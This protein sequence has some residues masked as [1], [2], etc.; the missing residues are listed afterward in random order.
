MRTSQVVNIR[1]G[2]IAPSHWTHRV[3]PFPKKRVF[4][5][6][7]QL[8]QDQGLL[9]IKHE[10]PLIMTLA[11][12]KG[13]AKLEGWS[14]P[15]RRDKIRRRIIWLSTNTTRLVIS[16]ITSYGLRGGVVIYQITPI[17]QRPACTPREQE[18]I[19][20]EYVRN[21]TLPTSVTQ[22][23]LMSISLTWVDLVH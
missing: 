1:V 8:T 22:T 20:N 12:H 14:K 19:P 2:A 18:L 5:G 11:L 15:I 13:N 7:F 4:T 16:S 6:G 3:I 17:Y 21:E 10:N 9:V 23:W